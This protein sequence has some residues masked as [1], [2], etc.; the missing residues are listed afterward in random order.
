MQ[1]NDSNIWNV[2]PPKVGNKYAVHQ[3]LLFFDALHAASNFSHF[4]QTET[5]LHTLLSPFP[6]YVPYC[7][8]LLTVNCSRSQPLQGKQQHIQLVP[9]LEASN[10]SYYRVVC[11]FI[12]YL[13]H[14]GSSN[15][16]MEYE[17]SLFPWNPFIRLWWKHK[18]LSI[19]SSEQKKSI[20]DSETEFFWAE[21]Q[22]I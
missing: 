18:V 1:L 19:T 21:L 14:C 13:H 5:L 6:S 20:S 9:L 8:W 7:H 16:P 10:P 4:S 15:R 17:N 2:D 22:D 3:H 12:S 11:L